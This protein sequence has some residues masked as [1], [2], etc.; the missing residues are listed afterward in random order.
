MPVGYDSKD[1]NTPN[2]ADTKVGMRNL[3]LPSTRLAKLMRCTT[4]TLQLEVCNG[5]KNSRAAAV[6]GRIR[7]VVKETRNSKQSEIFEKRTN[8]SSF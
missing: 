1:N 2:T 4:L 7:N 6:I 3:D 5:I 8:K